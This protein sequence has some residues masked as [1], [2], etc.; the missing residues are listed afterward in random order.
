MTAEAIFA[1][2]ARGGSPRALEIAQ[3]PGAT[4]ERFL[5]FD[6]CAHHAFRVSPICPGGIP[7]P[8]PIR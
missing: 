6:Q 2:P 8:W 1:P 4:D 7:M 5:Y 3:D